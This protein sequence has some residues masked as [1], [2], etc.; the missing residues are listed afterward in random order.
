MNRSRVSVFRLMICLVWPGLPLAAGEPTYPVTLTPVVIPQL[1][2]EAVRHLYMNPEGIL[3]VA[4][5][6]RLLIRR[7]DRVTVNNLKVTAM[8]GDSQGRLWLGAD[9]VLMLFDLQGIGKVVDGSEN[10]G[11]PEALHWADGRLW[12]ASSEQLVTYSP[13]RGFQIV[14]D[15]PR[16]SPPR[17]ILPLNEQKGYFV[18]DDGLYRRHGKSVRQLIPRQ[19]ALAR[20]HSGWFWFAADKLYRWREGESPRPMDSGFRALRVDILAVDRSN[21]LWAASETGLRRIDSRLGSVQGVTFMGDSFPVS[22]LAWDVDGRL[23]L[24]NRYGVFIQRAHGLSQRPL[25][26]TNPAVT[27]H[28]EGDVVH[29]DIRAKGLVSDTRFAYR[30]QPLENEWQQ[31]GIGRIHYR[32]LR[33]GT[34]RFQV[35]SLPL[36]SGDPELLEN[37]LVEVPASPGILLPLLAGAGGLGLVLLL[38]WR[39]RRKAGGQ[40]VV[41]G[42]PGRGDV[43]EPSSIS[44]SDSPE[45]G[46]LLVVD[47]HESNLQ[48]IGQHLR[49]HHITCA[50]SGREALA[51]LENGD[52]QLVLLDVMMPGMSG[53]EVCEAL[54]KAHAM[55]KLPV[56]FLTVRNRTEDMVR[57][58]RAGANDYL[59][60]PISRQEL[61][62]RVEMHLKLR[63]YHQMM[64]AKQ[65]L[66]QKEVELERVSRLSRESELKLLHAQIKPHFLQNT[67]TTISHL[68]LSSPG[69]AVAML[70]ELSTLM[71]QSV[72]GMPREWWPLDDEMQA[73]H[74][75]CNIQRRRFPDR[76]TLVLPNRDRLPHVKVPC[77]L[78]QP[79]VENAVV[80]G[81]REVEKLEVSLE[82]TYLDSHLQ[83]MVTNDGE[84][85]LGE[86]KDLLR[87]DHALGNIQQRLQLLFNESLDYRFRDGKHHFGF[88]IAVQGVSRGGKHEG[89]TRARD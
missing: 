16:Q 30:L 20:D 39:R 63:H 23:A 26:E 73:V 7:D 85:S 45:Q 33:P 84:Q 35:A 21:I 51:L 64:E 60:K 31:T 9:K 12:F 81:F 47:D 32:G 8:R 86:V 43:T 80:H 29:I 54:R 74:A 77:F 55:E 41:L 18:T 68:C 6:S 89:A 1:R 50:R 61:L 53:Y 76:L 3:Y 34:Y 70:G 65:R 83:V 5:D 48:V 69:D 57:G 11:K 58:F 66:L 79:L 44:F 4:T 87:E 40:R 13:E 37:Q 24:G 67:L 49:R 38:L 88:R 71:R 25:P 46:R 59:T 72:H 36:A 15:H 14:A 52:F 75:F 10:W 82:L 78:I 22:C 42:G 62:A 17:Q 2:Q 19:G 28:S 27:S 56:L